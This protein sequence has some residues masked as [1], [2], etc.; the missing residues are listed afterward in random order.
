MP[1]QP[2]MTV[3]EF[4]EKWSNAALREKANSQTHFN[5]LCAVV[6]VETPLEG[7]PSGETYTFEKRVDLHDG[8]SGQADVWK[9][10]RF[11]WEYKSGGKSLVDAYEQ[12]SGYREGLGNPPLL[13]VSDMSRFEIH[14]NF[15]N[16]AP[17]VIAFSHRD[18]RENPA[19][20]RRILRDV[21]TAPENLHPHNDPRYI[22]ET[23]AE[24]FGEV[25]AVLRDRDGQD[26]AIV[27]RFLNRIIFCLFA[28]SV[29]L[30]ADPGGRVTQPM[31]HALGNLVEW[32]E[33]TVEMLQPL[34]TAMAEQSVHLFGPY[35]IRWFDGSLFDERSAEDVMPLTT[36]LVEILLETSELNW[37]R[38]DPAIFGT[39][40]ERGLDPRRRS[41]LGA[42]YTDPENIMRV[43]EPV[44]L[45]PL[46][47]EFNELKED[48]APPG[49]EE[50]PAAYAANGELALAVPPDS[51]R[52]KI[53]AFLER[54]ANVRVLDPACG[55]GN[56][57]YVAMRAL[58]D[59][60][61]EVIEWA[62]DALGDSGL[63]RRVGPDNMCGIDID[64]LAVELT[65]MSLWIGII[66]WNL[67]H[68]F[69]DLR[70]P[71]LG[72]TEQIECRDA[73]L[74]EDEQGE[75]VPA[76]WPKTDYII[77]N[78][79]FLGAKRVLEELGED[80]AE[81][82]RIA[83][84]DALDARA[85]LCVYWHEVARRQIERGA[86]QTAGLLAT[87]SI[88]G[89]YSR[90]VLE[91]ISE[92]GR[93]FFAHSDEEWVNDGAAVRISIVGQ[94]G[95]N[96][97]V[98]SLDDEPV[99]HI[100]PN[101]T[102]GLYVV[103]APQLPENDGTAFQGDV[104]NGPFDIPREEA[105]R[106]LA[107]PISYRGRYN[108][109]VIFPFVIARDLAQRPRGRYIIDFGQDM[110]EREAEFYE[111]PFI[112]LERYVR[113]EREKSDDARLR[114]RWWLHQL[115][116]PAMRRAISDLDRYIATPITSKHRF[117][118]WLE[119]NVIPDATVVAI[120]RSDDYTF[121]VLHSRIHETWALAQ[122][123]RLATGNNYRY[124]HTQCFNTFPFPW[125]LNTPDAELSDEQR[126][127][128]D[129]IAAAAIELDGVRD[130]WLN[131]PGVNPILTED[132]TMTALYNA[133][134]RSVRRAHEALDTTVAAAYGWPA[135][136]SNDD[137]L[138]GLLALNRERAPQPAAV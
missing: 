84:D 69:R 42:H 83:Y 46:R 15:T 18:L 110:E 64:P 32:P 85:D 60:E 21:F 2:T 59:L 80:R 122:A 43:V 1:P 111:A 63:R 130:H 76:D 40:F 58:K 98:F 5:D 123:S 19:H 134:S 31:R 108:D 8:S 79:P 50:P 16:T 99:S 37:S 56:F 71:V 127:Q 77:G 67:D 93:I 91:R 114:E 39:L 131:P 3:D 116:R 78:P 103:G 72:R 9:Q 117:Y 115:W 132:R 75:P 53:R 97:P 30:F 28:E 33:L 29:G 35:T 86:A 36:D 119:P 90:P 38:I 66:Q 135:D 118:V 81:R 94:S 121:G 52:G 92:S 11:G 7:D 88:V 129:A 102:R 100:N 74:A 73:I 68:D 61:H 128:R 41:Q 95:P 51:P 120:A 133:P 17:R 57:L 89:P 96:E 125:P 49:V 104:R 26:A 87:N 112:H 124:V 20:F 22:T 62:Q 126:A 13:V 47:A 113:P 34:F 55:S 23:A 48:L 14:T 136:I 109:D 137:I 138:A 44:V 45:R 6:G 27:A 82:L 4:V 65:R 106:M 10:D 24:K 25:A 101:L 105:E 107:E 12:L 54:L 70:D